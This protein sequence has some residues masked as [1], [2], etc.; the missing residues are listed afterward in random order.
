ASSNRPRSN[1]LRR[2]PDYGSERNR[3]SPAERSSVL[4]TRRLFAMRAS[5]LK[6][7]PNVDR[8]DVRLG[9]KA[10]TLTCP[11]GRH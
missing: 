1:R 4:F 11:E 3:R 10:E 6:D 5:V 2:W 7:R 9:S 8:R